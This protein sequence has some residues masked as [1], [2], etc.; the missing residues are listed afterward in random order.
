[1]VSLMRD[2]CDRAIGRNVLERDT[3]LRDGF[4][5]GFPDESHITGG[6]RLQS[7]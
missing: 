5:A 7:P 4:E 2:G 1:M 6:S 3:V